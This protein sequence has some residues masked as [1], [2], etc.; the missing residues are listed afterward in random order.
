VIEQHFY[1][2]AKKGVFRQSEGYDTVAKSPGLSD[3]FVK[4]CLHPYS[5]YYPPVKKSVTLINLPCGKMLFGQTILV[6]KDFTGLRSTFFC[7]NYILPAFMVHEYLNDIGLLFSISFDEVH[8]KDLAALDLLPINPKSSF[9]IFFCECKI[10][11]LVSDIVSKVCISINSSKKVYVVVSCSF[12][13]WH[14]VVLYLLTK[15]YDDLPAVVKHRLGFST[16]TC[17]PVSKQGLHLVF[18][19]D[20]SYNNIKTLIKN[21]YIVHIN[22]EEQK[23][24]PFE[25]LDVN[26]I[27]VEKDY[28]CNNIML[29]APNSFLSGVEFWRLRL[30]KFNDEIGICESKWLSA[31]LEKL[32]ITFISNIKA[33]IITKGINGSEP[34]VYLVL[35]IIKNIA[36]NLKKDTNFDVRYYIGSYLLPKESVKRIYNNLKRLDLIL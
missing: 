20:S 18:I 33:K 16:Y 14:E 29:L 31:N 6:E 3:E 35:H 34:L 5:V 1:T 26:K 11:L 15:V 10:D 22:R 21:D 19:D 28:L 32:S 24:L 27:F 9:S 8:N 12:E 2:R 17:E 4:K 30:S 25:K 36:G 13:D 7:H 23:H